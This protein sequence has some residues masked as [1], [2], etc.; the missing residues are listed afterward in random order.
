MPSAE[1]PRLG[2]PFPDNLN[3]ETS[4]DLRIPSICGHATTGLTR[5]RATLRAAGLGEFIRISSDCPV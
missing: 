1:L 2:R 5:Y 4:Q 3:E